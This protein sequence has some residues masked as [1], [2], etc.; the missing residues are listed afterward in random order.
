MISLLR[1]HVVKNLQPELDSA[2]QFYGSDLDLLHTSCEHS[3]VSPTW[4]QKNDILSLLPGVQSRY[5]YSTEADTSNDPVLPKLSNA[6]AYTEK[7]LTSY[8]WKWVS[9]SEY[10]S[11]L[12]TS[13]VF[14]S[15]FV[16]KL[17]LQC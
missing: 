16:E 17:P 7:G 5:L 3:S 1:L 9:L 10:W 15:I 13:L 2:V 11:A 12:C 6:P 4:Y 8:I 14:C